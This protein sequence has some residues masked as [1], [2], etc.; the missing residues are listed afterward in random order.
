LREN[1]WVILNGVRLHYLDWGNA[2]VAS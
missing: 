1:R 2:R